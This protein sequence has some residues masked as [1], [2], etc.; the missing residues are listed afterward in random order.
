ME[1]K[2]LSRVEIALYCLFGAGVA[3]LVESVW[4]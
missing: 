1:R 4:S 3:W 2:F